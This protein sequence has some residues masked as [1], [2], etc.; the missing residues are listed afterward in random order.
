MSVSGFFNDYCHL[1]Y[2]LKKKSGLFLIMLYEQHLSYEYFTLKSV[3]TV[4]VWQNI[5]RQKNML[6]YGSKKNM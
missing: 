4:P 2:V 5:M 1:T 6:V 3:C